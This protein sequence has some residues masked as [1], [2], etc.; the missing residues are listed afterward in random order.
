MTVYDK[1]VEFQSFDDDAGEWK[2]F[3]RSLARVNNAGGMTGSQDDVERPV[4]TLEFS[5]RWQ[6]KMDEIRP[7]LENARLVYMG[8]AYTALS[9][10]DYMEAHREVRI[11]G[12]F[13]G[14]N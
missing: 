4:E 12:S 13:Y 2:T 5:M 11:K 7:K 6:R 8:R 3:M 9:Y 10:D 1:L 14:W